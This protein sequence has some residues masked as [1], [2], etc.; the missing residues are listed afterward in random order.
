MKTQWCKSTGLCISYVPPPPTIKNGDVVTYSRQNKHHSGEPTAYGGV[1]GIVNGLDETGA[2]T[3][4]GTCHLHIIGTY[5][6]G[7]G[8]VGQSKYCLLEKDGI[9]FRHFFKHNK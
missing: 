1:T 6:K 5:R 4:S 3:I 8:A 2:F 9:T 7:C